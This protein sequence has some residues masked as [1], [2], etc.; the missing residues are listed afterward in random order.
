MRYLKQFGVIILVTCVAEIM[1][2][3]IT[4][5]IPASIYGMCIMM[6]LLVTKVIKLD[7]VKNVG[8]FLIEIMP[9]MFIPAAV[10]VMA[11][12]GQL[13]G[14]VVPIV[15]IIIISTVL[16]MAVAGSVTQYVIRKEKKDE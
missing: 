10:G 2:F 3:Y 14:I 13:Q 11:T 9:V 12:W 8:M 1:K 6:L 15:I 5:P 7:D 16:V 4:L